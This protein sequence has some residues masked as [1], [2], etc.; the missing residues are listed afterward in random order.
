MGEVISRSRWARSW[1]DSE[2][3][4]KAKSENERVLVA[5]LFHA[6]LQLRG[7]LDLDLDSGYPK[8]HCV[9]G[10]STLF[11]QWCRVLRRPIPCY[12]AV[13]G[14][15][16]MLMGHHVCRDVVLRLLLGTDLN[17]VREVQVFRSEER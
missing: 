12:I 13:W 17:L 3:V 5:E 14:F 16:D 6:T 4:R 15:L 8:T 10:R 9:E 11:R 2:V 1:W 7:R